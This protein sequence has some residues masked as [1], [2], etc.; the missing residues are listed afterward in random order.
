MRYCIHCGATIN[1][2]WIYCVKCGKS[3][4]NNSYAN[5]IYDS[6]YKVTE[7]TECEYCNCK[8]IT[9]YTSTENK[10]GRFTVTCN[11]CGA[12]AIK[13]IKVEG[14]LQHKVVD[15]PIVNSYTPKPQPIVKKPNF[16]PTGLIVFFMF[17]Y[18]PIGIILLIT[19][20]CQK[21]KYQV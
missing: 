5:I 1:N 10:S 20:G 17:C 13:T 4:P 12:G 8:D 15:T 16:I 19:R 21:R 6:K 14:T 7:T 3:T 18:P 2:D 11:H 9:S